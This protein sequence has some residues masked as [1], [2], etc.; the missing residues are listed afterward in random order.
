MERHPDLR[1]GFV[2]GGGFSPFQVGR[3]DHGWKVRPEP[4]EHIGDRPP[5][6]YYRRFY[7]DTLTHDRASLLL[8]GE[9][10][11]WDHVMLGTDFPF[12]MADDDPV[13]KVDA[14]PL[15]PADRTRV[16]ETNAQGFLRPIPS[17]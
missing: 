13:T 16:L 1:V 8:L 17:R 4:K 15:S 5:S 9:R 11:G 10:V 6:T 14:A 7:F 2:H 3:W 12:D